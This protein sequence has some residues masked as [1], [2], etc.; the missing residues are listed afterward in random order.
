MYI[1]AINKLY[2]AAIFCNCLIKLGKWFYQINDR[3]IFKIINL[4]VFCLAIKIFIL[5]FIF[6]RSKTRIK[7]KYFYKN[8]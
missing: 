5:D 6:R 1:I 3:Q 2:L 7:S 4:R 8:I